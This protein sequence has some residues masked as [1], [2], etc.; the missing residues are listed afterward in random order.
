MGQSMRSNLGGNSHNTPGPGSHNTTNWD[1][2][3]RA[4]NGSTFGPKEH[5]RQ[6]DRGKDLISS[7]KTPGPGAYSVGRNSCHAPSY[8]MSGA[9]YSKDLSYAPG[10]GAYEP[11]FSNKGDDRASL[12]GNGGR[13]AISVGK[14]GPGPG[15]YDPHASHSGSVTYSIGTSVRKQS[16]SDKVPGPGAY[17]VPYYVAEVPRY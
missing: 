10:P 16:K 15:A 9:K 14:K 5:K 2:A 11:N 7:S 13:S 17:K 12:I 8:S 4:G 3:S 6:A 1:T